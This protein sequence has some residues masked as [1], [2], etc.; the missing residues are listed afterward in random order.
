MCATQRE[1]P[2]HAKGRDGTS[3]H[4]WRAVR[5]GGTEG[6]RGARLALLMLTPGGGRGGRGTSLCS[7]VFPRVPCGEAVAH[8]TGFWPMGCGRKWLIQFLELPFSA[9]GTQRNTQLT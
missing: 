7:S 6:E 8:A 2:E 1:E 4:A 9:L 5:V 3:P